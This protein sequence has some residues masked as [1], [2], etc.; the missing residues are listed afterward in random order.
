MDFAEHLKLGNLPTG[1][2]IY[3]QTKV[4]ERA[5]QR[6]MR[7][8]VEH[9]RKAI[10]HDRETL[11]VELSR[12]GMTQARFDPDAMRLD[13]LLDRSITGLDAFL[14][15]FIRIYG[16]DH[17]LGAAAAELRSEIFP[18]GVRAITSLPYIQEEQAVAAVLARL[19]SER[20]QELLAK[21]PGA[22]MLIARITE[23]HQEYRA[24]LYKDQDGPSQEDVQ[25]MQYR[26]QQYVY[27]TV[28]LI[29]GHNVRTGDDHTTEHLLEPILRQVQDV[30]EARR[31]RRTPTDVN[32]D[33]GEPEV[34]G[35][36]A[37]AKT[38]EPAPAE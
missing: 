5:D 14:E 6:T 25:E 4:L 15:S 2:R 38:G 21:L 35:S 28:V 7:D 17:E 8:L 34:P 32:P 29:L 3:A 26:G 11:Q 10:A 23:R 1:R 36:E 9:V 12:L 27:G 16:L 30:R 19:Q 24:A 20:A 37:D 31:R 18:T 33:T 13:A 22:D